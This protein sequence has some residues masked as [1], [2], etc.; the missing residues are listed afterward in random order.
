[1]NGPP[2]VPP[3]KGEARVVV[4]EPFFENTQWETKSRAER[5]QVMGTYSLTPR[6]VTVVREVAEKPLYAQV[7]A[8]EHEHRGALAALQRLRPGWRVVSPSALGTVDGPVTVVRTVV[9]EVELVESNRSS[10]TFTLVLGFFLP[11]LL[12]LQMDPVHETQR[13]HG[14]VSRYDADAAEVR[15]RLLR[16]PTQPDAAVDTRGW[17][18]L[19]R[20]FGLDVE[21][22]EGVMASDESRAPVLVSALAQRLAVAM[23]ALVEEPR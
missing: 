18:P 13:V 8:L 22:E 16:Y 4:I 6:D 3:D 15:K 21:F 17:V 7:R 2:A 12:L 1:M 23:V 10:K 19:S 20:P 11:P 14:V 5:A 9:G